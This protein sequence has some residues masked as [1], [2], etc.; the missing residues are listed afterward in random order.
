[1]AADREITQAF[2]DLGEETQKVILRE[3]KRDPS[4]RYICVG[5]EATYTSRWV[6]V[7]CGDCRGQLVDEWGNAKSESGD[8]GGTHPV[9][10]APLGKPV[11]E[12]AARTDGGR[13]VALLIVGIVAVAT[14]VGS[15]GMIR[16]NDAL[17][18]AMYAVM[19]VIQ[20]GFMVYIGGN[21]EDM[22]AGGRVGS[23]VAAI[24]LPP[25]IVIILGTA[26]L[27]GL[28]VLLVLGLLVTWLLS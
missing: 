9:E 5:C 19:F 14:L 8:A 17:N 6:M 20:L 1:M 18:G 23:V 22:G 26:I 4:A 28:A 25:I 27:I 2:A 3:L 13:L 15:I 24:A 16:N 21:F 12:L 11:E 7:R 10:R